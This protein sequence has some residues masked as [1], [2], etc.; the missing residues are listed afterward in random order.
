MVVRTVFI[1]IFC[2]IF[3]E[4]QYF[5]IIIGTLTFFICI[6]ISS[7]YS[8]SFSCNGL[9][10]YDYLSISLSVLTCYICLLSYICRKR[11]IRYKSFIMLI[12]FLLLSLVL[13]FNVRRF[14]VFF[15]IFES[16][17]S[18]LIFII[19]GWGA[20]PERL[21]ACTY[22]FIYTV[23]GSLFFL[24]GVGFLYFNGFRDRMC[25]IINLNNKRIHFFWWLFLIGFL[26][27][28]PIYPFHLWLPKAH[29]EAPVAGSMLLAGV[30]L[31]LGGY[32]LIRFLYFF[33]FRYI[34]L[35]YGFILNVCLL[36]GVYCSFV[37]LR[38]V[39]LKC[40]VAYSSVV[41]I[42][43]VVLGIFR[44]CYVGVI[45]SLIIIIGHGLC[46]SGLF[47]CVT[48]LY[49][50]RSSRRLLMNKGFVI[51]SPL[52]TILFFLLISRNIAAP[53]RLNLLGEIIIFLS[54][55][56]VRWFFFGFLRIMRFIGAAYCLFLYTSCCHGK[57]SHYLIS[58]NTI[59][60][61]DYIILFL[62]WLPLNFLLLFVI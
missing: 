59:Q 31:K 34:N 53:P 11:V 17:L 25:G 27:K 23:F 56:S 52:I 7:F 45:G 21:Q 49:K 43:L 24:I 19:M 1:C 4:F 44:N 12:N 41:H 35:I 46:S 13:A 38:Q 9:V 29:V 61:L 32:G 60:Y 48:C 10:Y 8:L 16:V 18:I 36:G 30:V 3:M 28:M 2:L 42:S 40:L 20:Q 22:I 58:N 14:F 37:C 26:I 51:S 33:L 39:D 50:S 54:C 57:N 6:S 55:Y 62:H 5:L 15:F 47:S